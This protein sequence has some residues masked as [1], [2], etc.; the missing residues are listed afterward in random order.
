MY[1]TP[2]QCGLYPLGLPTYSIPH[3]TNT[4]INELSISFSG[5]ASGL[6]TTSW[7]E[8]LVK[9]KQAKV[10]TLEEQKSAMVACRETLNSIKS[11]FSSFRSVL[12]KVTDVKFG[13]A[14][15]DI[16]AQKLATSSNA[17]VL[18][19]LATNEALEATYNIDVNQLAS[20]TS[21]MSGYTKT[22]TVVTTELANL[23]TKLSTLG[24]GI[25]DVGINVGATSTN[26]TIGENDTISSLIGKLRNIGV[27]ANYNEN[28][29]IFSVKLNRSQI[30][31]TI[32]NTGICDIL[33]LTQ[34]GGWESSALE[35]VD[36]ETI[37]SAATAS[38][39]LS[40]LGTINAGNI[41]V[42]SNGI[43]S[44]IAIDGNTTLGELIN[45]LKDKGVNAELSSD[46]VFTVKD[47]E[48]T[49]IGGTGILDVLGIEDTVNSKTQDSKD[50]SFQ[51]IVTT[52]TDATNSTKLNQL[53]AW[54]EVGS[55]P[56]LTVD[57][58]EIDVNN[59]D[60][61]IGELITAL[62][63]KGVSASINNG[64]LTVEGA[65]V[66]GSVADALG[67]SSGANTGGVSQAGVSTVL[68]TLTTYAT[69]D[70]KLS[71]L[72]ITDE[73]LE[74]YDS[75]NNAVA[76]I[77]ATSTSTIN[78]LFDSL[79][80]YGISGTISDGKITLTSSSGSYV[81]G[82][83]AEKLGIGTEAV[84]STTT[85]GKE[86]TSTVQLQ[87]TTTTHA[88]GST[89]ISDCVDIS[90]GEILVFK[91]CD[92]DSFSETF[93]IDSDTTFDDWINKCQEY[94][95]TM[96]MTNETISFSSTNG[97]YI[98]D[99]MELDSDTRTT[100]PISVTSSVP[101][102]Y[103]VAGELTLDTTIG[104]VLDGDSWLL[105]VEDI[106]DNCNAGT[107]TVT[108][109]MTFG[110]L[111]SELATYG[112]N[113]S[114]NSNGTLSLTSP[115]DVHRYVEGSFASAVGWDS[116]IS[117]QTFGS[118]MTGNTV[119]QTITTSGG[120]TTVVTSVS[121]S[122]LT[123]KLQSVES[124]TTLTVSASQTSKALT[125]QSISTQVTEGTTT[126]YQ[127]TVVGLS[128]S[129]SSTITYTT[130]TVTPSTETSTLLVTTTIGQTQSS[131]EAITYDSII[132]S[133]T[134]GYS[135]EYVTT[136][137]GLTQS[138]NTLTNDSVSYNTTFVTTTVAMSQTSGTLICTLTK[139]TTTTT[140]STAALSQTGSTIYTNSGSFATMSNSLQEIGWAQGESSALLIRNKNNGNAT[141]LNVDSTMSLRVLLDELRIAG[142]KATFCNGVMSIDG[143][144]SSAYIESEIAT[145]SL[146]ANF[147][148]LNFGSGWSYVVEEEQHMTTTTATGTATDSTPFIGLLIS[149]G[150]TY[151]GGS[152]GIT[153]SDGS[154]ITLPPVS[155]MQTF[156]QALNNAGVTASLSDG[157]LTIGSETDSVCIT[158]CDALPYL[159][160]S[161]GENNSYRLESTQQVS[162]VTTQVTAT[163]STKLDTL[164]EYSNYYYTLVDGNGT[165]HSYTVSKSGGST[166]GD[167]IADLN[168]A[169]IN[170][171][172]DDGVLSITGGNG[173]IK[174]MDA[175]LA[176]LFGL[177]IGEGSSYSTNV[178]TNVTETTEYTTVTTQVTATLDTTF[179][180]LGLNDSYYNFTA[181]VDGTVVATRFNTGSNT[182]IGDF[183]DFLE[184]YGFVT[185]FSG[186]I[187][188]IQGDETHYIKGADLAFAEAICIDFGEAD[189]YI[190]EMNT[191][192]Q[193]TTVYTTATTQVTATADTT[194]R[195]LG[196]NDPYYYFTA[197]VHGSEVINFTTNNDT[198]IGDFVDFLNDNG[199][200]ASFSNGILSVS[201]QE[202]IYITK[203]EGAFEDALYLRSGEG[204]SYRV[205]ITTIVQDTTGTLTVTTTVTATSDTTFGTL[206]LTG[207]PIVTVV[208]DSGVEYNYTVNSSSTIGD[209]TNFLTSHDMTVSFNTGIIGILGG[210][211]YIKSIEA[212]DSNWNDV[213]G[214]SVRSNTTVTV[215]TTTTYPT[216][217]EDTELSAYVGSNGL[218]GTIKVVT[219]DGSTQNVTLSSSE[220]Y[221]DLID[222]LADVG[223]TASLTDGVFTLGS[224]SDTSYVKSMDIWVKSALGLSVGNNYTTTEQSAT[225]TST[226]TI[227]GSTT[228]RDLGIA[229][230]SYAFTVGVDGSLVASTLQVD[231]TTT[232]DDFISFVNGTGLIASLTDGKIT[233]SSSNVNDI[234]LDSMDSTLATALG[235]SGAVNGVYYLMDGIGENP[236]SNVLV[237]TITCTL[238][239]STTF[240][241]LGLTGSNYSYT[242]GRYGQVGVVDGYDSSTT[243]GEFIQDMNS[244]LN[245]PLNASISDGKITIEG[246]E[247][248]CI[249]SMDAELANALGLT[250]GNGLSY[251][252]SGSVTYA[253]DCENSF[254]QTI[255]AAATSDTTLGELGFS[256]NGTIVTHSTSGVST[257]ITVDS[258]TTLGSLPYV[259]V[260]DG[261]ISFSSTD[262]YIYS[263]SDNL[264]SALKLAGSGEGYSYEIQGGT[265]Y[266]NTNTKTLQVTTTTV[267]DS[268]SQ[269]GNLAGIPDSPTLVISTKSKDG[270]INTQTFNFSKTDTLDSVLSK[271]AENGINATIGAD[272]KINLSSDTLADF[273]VSGSLGDI[274]V[275]SG[276][277]K[278]YEVVAEL[279]ITTITTAV[280]AATRDTKLS[281]LGVT[282]GEYYIYKNGV[283]Y[284][285]QIT[286]DD[287]LGDF[288]DKLNTFGIHSEIIQNGGNS[289]LVLTGAGDS[290]VAK[291]QNAS[292]ASNVVETLFGADS[293]PE[294]SYNYSGS[295]LVSTTTTTT[296]T[297][298][299]DTLLSEFDTPWG[300]STLKAAGDLALTVNG[301][302][303]VVRITADETFGS[304]VDKLKDVGVQASFLNGVLYI[305]DADNV[306]IDSAR[307][308]SAII[309]PNAGI[310]LTQKDSIDGFLAS[311]DSVTI[312]TTTLEERTVSA[313]NYA[314][315]N[316][317][318]STLNI[319]SGTLSLYRNGEKALINVD[320]NW[321][322]NDLRAA[323]SAEFSDLELS[324]DEGKVKIFSK[325]DGVSVQIGSTTDGSNF[326]AITGMSTNEKGV[327]F[328]SRELYKANANSKIMTAGLFQRGDVTEGDFIVGD[329]KIT[330]DEN[331]TIADVISQINNKEETNSSAYWDSISGKLIINSKT[332]GAALINIEAG[333]SNFTDIMGFTTTERAADGSITQ[334]KLN[335]EMQD[336]GKNARFTING[337]SYTS[338]TNTVTSD[339]SKIKGV[340]LNLHDISGETVT[341]KIEKDK[342]TVVSNMEDVVNAYNEL[343][344]NVDKAIAIDGKLHGE[345]TLKTIRNQLRNYMTGS[346][347]GASVFRNLD[348]I[349]ISV[350]GAA[351]NN[352]STTNESIINLSFDKEKF[353]EAYEK[354]ADAVKALLVGSD[355]NKGVLTKVEELLESSL[356][357]V[358]GYFDSAE[359]SYK[360]KASNYETKIS[361]ANVSIERYRSQLEKKFSSM[362]MVIAKMQQQYSSY[363]GTS[364]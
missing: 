252:E 243:I 239:E 200:T 87:T 100:A 254:M 362:D 356:K 215:T 357:S 64:V 360:T 206:G 6:D 302:N 297:A 307:T 232:V 329:A 152:I 144:A 306:S 62:G 286:A 224:A 202:E 8:S 22:T 75:A 295:A 47:A 321:T 179:R 49:D 38:T 133:S 245:T 91:N 58:E 118:S 89:K 349:G 330:I 31:D 82:T 135:T 298:T 344:L 359:T 51:T 277:S 208:D 230:T 196:L 134:T 9:L 314:D 113:M 178:T 324:F 167:V 326:L 282:T 108:S 14:N 102:T 262:G 53:D 209:F 23:N 256:G 24:I 10:D 73:T 163:S 271:L 72:G 358:T 299:E 35:I 193:G 32:S 289:Q 131:Y 142:V 165:E 84:G 290:Y 105:S 285:S 319:S 148:K 140:T 3:I 43:T 269:L 275:G 226:V 334:T 21:A 204:E 176:D 81:N 159:G 121:G 155:T 253:E 233:M 266:S 225:T 189:S 83:M 323:I 237:P 70:T 250:V 336:I 231:D 69:G 353:L 146:V 317:K 168:S 85:V 103:T 212:T 33:N 129:S 13:V 264:L 325:T 164:G 65:E 223:V 60:M 138:G 181:V 55:N 186:G 16:F 347:A 28:S 42:K 80:G 291:S 221:G 354:D 150:Y 184:G 86:L 107:I 276:S 175:G 127:T 158:S 318:L 88:T 29:G 292:S 248:I 169:G 5:L 67:I 115:S 30:D 98:Q 229:G 322:F 294:T 300:G 311:S 217:T 197:F 220:T 27:D 2:C 320:E 211:G 120:T 238:S 287:T 136:T 240:A 242:I 4:R 101:V 273:T 198:T 219:S 160:I 123:Y 15:M 19:A 343:M 195:S 235:I 124:T 114:I 296:Q 126:T 332:A 201:G 11:F 171:T 203:M 79:S 249:R 199:F 313:S 161:V 57:G 50:L 288:I 214:I 327:S 308:T 192:V 315:L 309:N 37:V 331:T 316:T 170:A 116:I 301:E 99:Y 90:S 270:T 76:I 241:D 56:T 335:T 154:T 63:N 312:E 328:S 187:L 228:L 34:T 1:R 188:S 351:A 355:Q 310:K 77:T 279:N 147:L 162:S 361:K 236:D 68:Q 260:S 132:V 333:T 222:K 130:V 46:G 352:L 263:M 39:K 207:T 190:T 338:A 340:T 182:T 119:Y 41:E 213:V 278:N 177:S 234:Y 258:T 265:S 117:S 7:V 246:S 125:Y 348:A 151:N 157:K 191:V 45:N 137:T 59:G 66:S 153:L 17:A 364:V 268:T 156:V 74:V 94:G 112:L 93:T 185:D 183:I 304:L 128:Q 26:I 227:S 96:T 174:S 44:T 280:Q 303:K 272:G 52:V 173:Y 350:N 259:S 110:D 111:Q 180:S 283:K 293:T 210:N 25:G 305:S 12:E 20:N 166:V 172:F 216:V 337:T 106:A 78:D 281:D 194:F 48:I 92:D 145:V 36:T 257:T 255:T 339:I 346:D 97:F 345:T 109:T 247:V 342:D 274:L 95:I 284:T 251:Q 267:A 122:S 218:N 205:D 71:D 54:A 244:F 149:N 261:T 341:L 104:D 40:E 61:T 143:D 18:T 363:L 139:T 141:T